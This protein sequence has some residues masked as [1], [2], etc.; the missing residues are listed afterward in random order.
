MGSYYGDKEND[1]L[2]SEDEQTSEVSSFLDDEEEIPSEAETVI[3]HTNAE[4]SNS[5]DPYSLSSK[6]LTDPYVPSKTIS[7]LNTELLSNL[8]PYEL[9]SGLTEDQKN[10]II[11]QLSEVAKSRASVE[12]KSNKIVNSFWEYCNK[13]RKMGVVQLSALFSFKMIYFNLFI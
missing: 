13:K 6:G 4:T 5:F 11:K 9:N 3:E 7:E 12:K 2:A 8:N 10:F 1:T